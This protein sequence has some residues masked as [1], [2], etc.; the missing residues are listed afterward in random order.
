M[1]KQR[2]VAFGGGGAAAE[3]D[4]G[5]MHFE[6]WWQGKLSKGRS[7]GCVV[8]RDDD[9]GGG[10][11]AAC[12]FLLAAC[13]LLL[14]C[15]VDCGTCG[16]FALVEGFAKCRRNMKPN[17]GCDCGRRAGVE[18]GVFVIVAFRFFWLFFCVCV[19]ATSHFD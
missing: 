17:I 11:A 10:G 7:R 2:V 5:S 19:C 15:S 6:R 13:C 12:C 4:M 14:L 1:P 18:A 9:S 8:E 16:A 3:A